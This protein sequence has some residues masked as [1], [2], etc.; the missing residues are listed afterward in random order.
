M[1]KKENKYIR[2]LKKKLAKGIIKREDLTEG[3]INMLTIK[4]PKQTEEK[5]QIK[6]VQKEQVKE[7]PKK[8]QKE[9]VKD[10]TKIDGLLEQLEEQ[11]ETKSTNKAKPSKK[12][13]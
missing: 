8:V 3:D 5:V 4:L 11:V 6:K 12:K 2:G 1:I 9:Q 10:G 13:K 7:T